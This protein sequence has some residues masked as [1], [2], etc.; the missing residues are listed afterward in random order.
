MDPPSKL[1]KST[2]PL[3]SDRNINN[4]PDKGPPGEVDRGI[5]Q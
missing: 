4:M 5:L 1:I 2:E 3:G